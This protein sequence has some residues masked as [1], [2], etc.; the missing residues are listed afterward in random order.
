MRSPAS[1]VLGAKAAPTS[2]NLDVQTSGPIEEIANISAVALPLD[3]HDWLPSNYN[4]AALIRLCN[5][6]ELRTAN[7]AAL[8]GRFGEIIGRLI[9]GN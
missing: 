9:I 6:A 7:A 3:A 1:T 5:T 4:L 2:P 8:N